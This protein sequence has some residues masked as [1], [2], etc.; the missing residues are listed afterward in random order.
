ML[1]AE[2]PK[3]PA[4][5]QDYTHRP[6][7]SISSRSNPSRSPTMNR[8]CVSLI[9][10][11]A[12]AACQ[13]TPAGSPEIEA[14]TESTEER[15]P[16]NSV[17]IRNYDSVSIIRGDF[18]GPDVMKQIEERA[19]DKEPIRIDGLDIV[20]FTKAEVE[21]GGEFAIWRHRSEAGDFKVA[22]RAPVD[23]SFRMELSPSVEKTERLLQQVRD[24]YS[25]LNRSQAEILEGLV[26][27]GVARQKAEEFLQEWLPPRLRGCYDELVRMVRP[28]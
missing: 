6:G 28:D 9:A 26:L 2:L 4:H 25:R 16:N 27:A 7:A 21:A 1:G 18:F 10:V 17:E 20:D 22:C 11:L 19:G 12:L 8:K 24:R 13:G 23:G 5:D 15:I 14:G 3:A